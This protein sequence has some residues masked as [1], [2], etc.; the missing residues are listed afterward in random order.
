[1]R[2]MKEGISHRS[3]HHMKD[4]GCDYILHSGLQ[5][6]ITCFIV[7]PRQVQGLLSQVPQ[8]S[9]SCPWDELSCLQ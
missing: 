4:E 3:L 8:L 5:S 6:Q 7:L 2:E 9:L 1:M